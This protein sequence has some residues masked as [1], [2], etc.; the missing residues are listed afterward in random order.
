M[1]LAPAGV[2]PAGRLASR[3]SAARDGRS[4]G[5]RRARL[6]RRL[7]AILLMTEINGESQ[8]EP[9]IAQLEQI[10]EPASSGFG[11]GSCGQVPA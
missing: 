4:P 2:G 5:E 6:L 1:R 9:R 10:S 3:S 7:S 11:L 8:L